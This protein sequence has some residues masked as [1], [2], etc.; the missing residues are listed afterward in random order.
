MKTVFMSV[1]LGVLFVSTAMAVT[2][3]SAI[4][5]KGYVD[6]LVDSVPVGQPT[7]AAPTGRALLWVAE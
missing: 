4:T 3:T 6:G 5:S 7:T 1:L 2:S